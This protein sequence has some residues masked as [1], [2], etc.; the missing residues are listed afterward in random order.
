MQG[1]GE[2]HDLQDL[3]D[4]PQDLQWSGTGID[5]TD[6]GGR[7]EVENRRCLGFGLLKTTTHDIWIRV[8][9]AVLLQ[10]AFVNALEYRFLIGAQMQQQEHVDFVCKHL[11]L[12]ST[13]R[14]PIEKEH[15][16]SPQDATAHLNAMNAVGPSPWELSYS[17]G[18]VLQQP[19]LAAWLGKPQNVEAAQR[20][21]GQRARLNSLARSGAYDASMDLAAWRDSGV[22]SDEGKAEVFLSRLQAVQFVV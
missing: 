11:R 6:L 21:F 16:S 5:R 9:E 12:R 17:Y 22:E 18:R 20:A 13:P 1:L 14:Y 10:G 15:V 4:L 19:A 3:D 7:T 8:V 2:E